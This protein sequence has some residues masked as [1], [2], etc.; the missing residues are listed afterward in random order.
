MKKGTEALIS[1]GPRSNL[2]LFQHYGF[3]LTDNKCDSYQFHARL[4]VDLNK[5]QDVEDLIAA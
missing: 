1:Y 2:F 4:C 3:S 5:D